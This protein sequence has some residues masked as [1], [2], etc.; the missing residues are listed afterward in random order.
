[1]KRAF[2]G[3]LAILA[4]PVLAVADDQIQIPWGNKFFAPKDP[5]PVIV[6]DFGTV[7]SGTTLFHRFNL[8]NIYAVPMQI[9]KDPEV[10]CGCV[11]V[12]KY[13]QKLEPR[14][15]GFVDVEMDGR[16]FIGAKSVTIQVRFGP[17][18]QSTAILQ[19]RAFG[20]TDVQINPGQVNFGVVALGQKPAQNIDVQYTGQQINW[21]I[22]ELDTSNAPSVAATMQRLQPV[23]GNGTIFRIAVA[24]KPDAESGVLQE[25]I[26]LKTNDATSPLLTLPVTGT[27]QSP[28]SVVQGT[29]IRLDP[30]PVGREATKIVMVRGN[31]PFKIMKVEG[32]GDGLTVMYDK[33][34]IAIQ[35]LTVTFKPTQPGELKRKLI[36][37]TDQ[38]EST[39]VT[40]EG[41]AEAP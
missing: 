2:W 38:N 5:P 21:Q 8:T 33:N 25:Q 20:R 11:R 23:R 40:I 4:T 3:I 39:S 18:F 26:V 22:N 1:M 10:S 12:V 29:N 30:V 16:R 24:L 19:V 36:I 31:K 41:T 35:R 32:E 9:V 15:S 13:T 14:E 17:K 6:H 28:L 7:P 34:P 27:V 37:L